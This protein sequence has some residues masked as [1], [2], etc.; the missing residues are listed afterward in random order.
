MDWQPPVASMR[1]CPLNV[2]YPERQRGDS[3]TQPRLASFT[4]GFSPV[5]SGSKE[6]A[7]RFN[8]FIFLSA[9]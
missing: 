1:T 9:H 6:P 3:S 8:G 2:E 4:P 5:I 7:N